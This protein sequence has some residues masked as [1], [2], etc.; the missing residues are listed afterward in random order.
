EGEQVSVLGRQ[1]VLQP[2]DQ[3]FVEDVGD[4]E[5]DPDR[6]QRN[7]DPRAELVEMLDEGRLLAV[8]KA[9]GQTSHCYGTGSCSRGCGGGAGVEEIG[10]AGSE[11][12]AVPGDLAALEQNEELVRRSLERFGRIDTFVANAIVTVYAEV[13]ELE[14]EELRRVFDVNFFGVAWAYRA[15]LP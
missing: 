9:T 2:A 10:R 11:A 1:R 15:A 3:P 13:E 4:D 14:P 5:S 7:D 6:D 8:T 12:L